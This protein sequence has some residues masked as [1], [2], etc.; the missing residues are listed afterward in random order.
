MIEILF[1]LGGCVYLQSQLL[2]NQS[3]ADYFFS[4]CTKLTLNTEFKKHN[5]LLSV[6]PVIPFA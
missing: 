6:N 2:P 1:Q 3:S 4:I 5:V